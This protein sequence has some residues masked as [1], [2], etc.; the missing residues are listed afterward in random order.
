MAART[1]SRC[2][3]RCCRR[4]RRP[5]SAAI[6]APTPLDAEHSHLIE[7]A[8]R[9]ILC[10]CRPC[11]IVFEPEGAAQ[12]KYRADSGRATRNRRDFAIED[13]HWDALQVPIGLAF[14]FY[15]S[16]EKKMVAFYPSPAGAT[17]SLLPLDTGSEIARA[18]SAAGFGGAGRRGDPHPA[19]SRRRA[20]LHRADRRGVRT[21]RADPHVLERLRRRRGGARKDR[22]VLREG[23]ASA[24][25]GKCDGAGSHD[26]SRLCRRRRARRTRTPPRRCSCCA[27]ASPRAAARRSTRS[28]CAR[29]SSSKCS[30]GAI[31]P[32]ESALLDGA[33]RRA[34]AIRRHAQTDAVD[35]RFDDGARLLKSETEVRTAR[36]VQLRFR[37]GRA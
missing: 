35:A 32:S 36:S 8:A 28:R 34:V 37:S 18:V 12:G 25:A 17:E 19:K 3:G 23:S 16:L 21:G 29:R 7:L 11:Y 4:G 15:N 13:A 30:A 9:R 6:S 27:C 31:R 20:L 5:A 1:T 33:L 26:G 22:R 24:A 2:S 10:A 14:F